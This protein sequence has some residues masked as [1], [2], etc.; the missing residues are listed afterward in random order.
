M[1][2]LLVTFSFSLMFLIASSSFLLKFIEKFS[3]RIKISPLVVGAT[4]VAIGTSLPETFVAFSS[5]AQK[6]VDISFG[7]VVGANIANIC[8]TIGL[9]ILLFP[10]RFGTQKT[11]RNNY[12]MILVTAYFIALMFIPP[13]L[14]KGLAVL[15]IAFYAVFLIVETVWGEIGRKKEDRK[16]LAK[17]ATKNGS[18]V[19]YFAGMAV[20][21]VGLLAS[22]HFLVKSVIQFS[23]LFNISEEI[24][25]LSVV[26]VG[27]ALP[28]LATSIASAFD[29]DWKLLYGNIQGSN[30]YNLA[31]VG[32]I[33]LI[34]NNLSYRMPVFPLAVLGVSTVTI[35]YL[36]HRYEGTHI[37]RLWGLLFIGFYAFYI[38]KIYQ[39]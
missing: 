35:V 27:T 29:K 18:V 10:V 13:P 1:L 9:G 24:I 30:I 34:A 2:G 4:V 8:L 5:I 36:S 22:S 37:P 33:L 3:G 12:I 23:V 11:Q 39:F 38:W 28:E 25:G 19:G 15:S 26:A 32:S 21:L 6:A 7:D 17:L 14:R 16:A 20:S 31:V